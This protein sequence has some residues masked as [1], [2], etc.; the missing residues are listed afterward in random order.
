MLYRDV[1]EA[2]SLT[3]DHE[4]RLADM[5]MFAFNQK[6]I[7]QEQSALQYGFSV[8]DKFGSVEPTP[9]DCC[10]M[11][12]P[13]TFRRNVVMGYKR[14]LIVGAQKA[15]TTFLTSM[16]SL[17]WRFRVG[18]CPVKITVKKDGQSKRKRR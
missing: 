3:Q 7:A 6:R 5:R 1:E 15:G 12:E 11:L 10:E 17:H 18:I 16:M 4:N 2:A 9:D 8:P 13:L 14:L